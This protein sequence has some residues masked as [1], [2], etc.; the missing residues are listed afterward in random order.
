MTVNLNPERLTI[1]EM[2]SINRLSTQALRHYDKKGILKPYYVDESNGYRYYHISQCMRLDLIQYL[3][4]TGASLDEIKDTLSSSDDTDS[5]LKLLKDRLSDIT[6]RIEEEINKKNILI[7]TIEN[8]EKYK[9]TSFD[10]KIF[11]EY[12]G[13]RKLYIYKTNYNY[14]EQGITGYELMLSEL[15]NF[16]RKQRIPF[17]YFSNIGTIM[18]KEC[19][20]SLNFYSDEVFF[21]VGKSLKNDPNVK[22]IEKGMYVC[23][24]CNDF[25]K[26]EHLANKLVRY[27]KDNDYKI[28][29]DYL[30]EV[31]LKFPSENEPPSCLYYKLQ[32]PIQKA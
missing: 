30:C 16:F 4:S 14:F 28:V 10:E 5:L 18:R 12:Q 29:G 27:I 11:L 24:C 1:G 26:E 22:K 3:K 17:N 23:I 32:I 25:N 13:D 9:K 7:A 2:A 31:S 8:Y 19:L 21:P 6:L 15:R 20:D